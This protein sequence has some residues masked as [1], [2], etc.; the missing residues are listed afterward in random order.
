MVLGDSFLHGGDYNPDQWLDRPD[1][2]DQDILLMKEANVNCVSVAIFAWARL[3]P[4]EGVYDFA[5]LAQIIDNLYKNGI[6]TVLATPSGARPAWLAQK[7]E[8]VLRVDEN[9]Q[10]RWMGGRHNHCFTSPVYRE[11]VRAMNMRL[12]EAFG[13]HPGVILWH[14][15]NEYGGTCYCPLCRDAFRDWVKDRYQTLDAVNKAWWMPFWS[16]TYS[17]WEQVEPPSP[18]GE[19]DTHGLNLAWKRF[20]T[21]RTADF[22]LMEKTSIRDAGSTLPITT[23]MMYYFYDLNYFKFKDIVDIASWD[24]YPSWHV[25]EDDGETA[26]WAGM[27][28]DLIRSIKKAPFLLMEST[29]SSL[30]WKPVSKLKKPGMHM[31]SSLQA[32]A[33]G[34]D[35]VQYFQ[36]R[37]GRGASEKFHGA[38]VDHYGKSDTRVF[39]EVE[40]L[41]SRLKD[42][43]FLHG[44]QVKAQVAIIFDWEN[45]WAV[46]DAAGPRNT[47]IHFLETLLDHYRAFW[48]MGI[49]V[50]LVDM[51]SSLDGYQLVAAPLL[52][53]YRAGFEKKLRDFVAA[54]GTL[55]GTYWSGIVN[56]DDLCYL[57]GAPYG[58]MDVYGLRE[59]EID[60]LNDGE[61]NSMTWEG[62]TYRLRDLCARPVSVT[63]EVLSVYGEDFYQGEPSLVKNSY[64]Q[65][66]A[67][68]LAARAEDS[69]FVDFYQKL[70]KKLSL[71]KAVPCSV[72]PDGVTA[73]ARYAGEEKIAV[74]QNYNETSVNVSFAG[75]MQDKE[76]G[77]IL[78]GTITLGKWQ[79]RFLKQL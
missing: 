39:Q 25:F 3:E 2:L 64:G 12:A 49:S 73:G 74:L 43:S 29:P 56:E 42:I 77:E 8:E 68:Y 45:R 13:H 53:M 66:T 22:C 59:E 76:T 46:S 44:A 55:V 54:G 71:E 78:N 30:N 63:G 24:S 72:L 41:G 51:E 23:N 31:L 36:W 35:S 52:Y 57:G 17:S 5:W 1:I 20:T 60:S 21:D 75:S 18:R 61:F 58:M 47:G 27:A 11:K 7:Y 32:V 16:H 4:E 70:A 37:K 6:N 69:F 62:K 50:D 19:S 9:G 65:G 79:V 26:V 14:L 48:K 38:V 34:S 40:A 15:S 10:R 67:Y 33:H 28:H